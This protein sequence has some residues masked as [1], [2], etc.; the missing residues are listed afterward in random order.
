M[1]PS[2]NRVLSTTGPSAASASLIVPRSERILQWLRKFH[3]WIGLW[4][5][6]LGLLFG[7]AGL[8]SE[9]IIAQS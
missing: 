9:T 1:E 4:G 3:G 7:T 5:A 2:L 8:W 6:V